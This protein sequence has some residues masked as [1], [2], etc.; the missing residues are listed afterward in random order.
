MKVTKKDYEYLK[1]VLTNNYN[2]IGKKKDFLLVPFKNEKNPIENLAWELL[3]YG[4]YPNFDITR[5]YNDNHLNTALLKI[6]Q[7]LE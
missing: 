2:K 3:F 1:N 5:K 4:G 6:L 7:G